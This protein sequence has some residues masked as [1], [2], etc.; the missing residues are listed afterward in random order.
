MQFEVTPNEAV[1]KVFFGADREEV[2]CVLNGF[3]GEF[4]K[5]KFSKNTTDDFGYCH[6][7][8]DTKD[9]CE[10]VEFFAEVE[11]QINGQKVSPGKVETIKKI[12]P[13]L[14]EEEDGFWISKSSAIGITAPEGSIETILFGCANYYN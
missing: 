11:I 5:S 4:K 1:G 6:V 14:I 2:R 10:A 12:M 13:D 3:K 9:K 8:Y 7:Y